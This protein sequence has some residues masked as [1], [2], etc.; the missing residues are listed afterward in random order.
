MITWSTVFLFE[1]ILVVKIRLQS[2]LMVKYR[3][4]IAE[5]SLISDRVASSEE[6]K[7]KVSVYAISL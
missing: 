6:M 7:R 5:M 4:Y 2:K 3:K 1:N